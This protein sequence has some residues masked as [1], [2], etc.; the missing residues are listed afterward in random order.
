MKRFFPLLLLSFLFLSCD[1]GD[2]IVQSFD[3]S[4]ADLKYCGEP[5]DYVFFKINAR[6]QESLSLKL[7]TSD[8]I[9]KLEE[10]KTYILNGTSEYV[11]YRNYDGT[12]GNDY[13]CRSVP[14]TSPNVIVDYFAGSG[15]AE[16]A[17]SYILEDEI[18]IKKR[19]KI[20]LRDISLISGDEKIIQETLEMG[21]IEIPIE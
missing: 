4:E 9:F 11:N 7:S 19:I 18:P 16:F 21:A 3:F 13:F 14:P 15:K 1:D 8:S 2:I 5:G 6:S 20:T 12:V 17:I 10:N